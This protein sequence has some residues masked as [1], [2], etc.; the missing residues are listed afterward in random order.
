MAWPAV[1]APIEIMFGKD[2][3]FGQPIAEKGRERRVQMFGKY[4]PDWMAYALRQHR[5]PSTLDRLNP[6]GI[7]G[8]AEKKGLFGLGQKRGGKFEPPESLRWLRELTGVKFYETNIKRNIEQQIRKL[9]SEKARY[10]GRIK[11]QVDEK[12]KNRLRDK[13]REIE[14]EIKYWKRYK[15]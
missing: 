10:S 3:Y 6:L 2:L 7:W 15:Y 9:H 12:E 13:I 11:W 5:L 4:V 1:K 8:S 14:R